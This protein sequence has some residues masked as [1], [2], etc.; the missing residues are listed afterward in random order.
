MVEGVLPSRLQFN[1]K[2]DIMKKLIIILSF[3]LLTVVSFSQV[4]SAV[5][6]EIHPMKGNTTI[7]T[8]MYEIM[9]YDLN[10]ASSFANDT[11]RYK[12][13]AGYQA[14]LTFVS[15]TYPDVYRIH[16]MFDK[17]DLC[18]VRFKIW[19]TLVA[20]YCSIINVELND[21][22]VTVTV[23]GVRYGQDADDKLLK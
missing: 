14:K 13:E 1:L 9:L 8:E 18:F 20:G 23:E 12:L 16:R 15:E 7:R 4:P 21:V 3:L 19:D 6:A 17:G 22:V 11:L 2:I 10:K 5:Y